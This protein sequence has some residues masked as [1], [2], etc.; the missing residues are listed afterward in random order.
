[1]RVSWAISQDLIEN[2]RSGHN[3]LV[4]AVVRLGT[5][6]SQV[7]VDAAV[8]GITLCSS[9]GI[10]LDNGDRF[11]KSEEVFDRPVDLC[12]PEF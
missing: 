8:D 11:T 5:F 9:D 2:F 7:H 6:G 1:M 12:F 10:A 3:K 4:S